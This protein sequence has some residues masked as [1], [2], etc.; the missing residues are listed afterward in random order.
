MGSETAE[1]S[2]RERT[3]GGILT[4]VPRTPAVA[5]GF[6]AACAFLAAIL[7]LVLN[8]APPAQEVEARTS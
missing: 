4:G 3:A 8:P 6:G 2:S 1:G 5:L 7:F